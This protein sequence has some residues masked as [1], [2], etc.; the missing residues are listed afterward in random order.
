MQ[1]LSLR[2]NVLY[3]YFYVFEVH[4]LDCG[5]RDLEKDFKYENK[6]KSYVYLLSDKGRHS[7]Q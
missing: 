5:C 3:V 1:L 7:F 6:V 4:Q 2:L